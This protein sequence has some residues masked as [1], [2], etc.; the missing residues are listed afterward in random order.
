MRFPKLTELDKDQNEIYNGAPPEGTVL[1]IGPPGTGKTVIAF[2]R[3]QM[4]SRLKRNPRVIMYNKV[5][6]Q[7]TSSRGSVAPDVEVQTLHKWAYDW[8]KRSIRGYGDPPCV[9]GARFDH[10]WTAIQNAAIKKSND[11]AGAKLVNWGHLIIDEGQD[12]PPSLYACLTNV[13]TVANAKGSSPKLAVTVLAD[14]NQRL[15]P[16]RNSN[17]E[18][19]RQ[20]LLLGPENFFHLKKNYRSTKQIAEFASCFYVGL[21]SGKP[22][23]PSSIGELPVVSWIERDT[24]G[25]FLDA[26]ATKIARYA[27][28]RR[29][30]E[31]GVL[32]VRDKVRSSIFNRLNAKLDEKKIKV[33]S[34]SSKDEELK[35]TNLEFDLP[36]SVTVINSASAKGLEF[37]TVFLIDPGALVSTGSG[38]LEAK[39]AMYVLCSR[40]RRFLN[41]MLVEDANSKKLMKDVSK[42]IYEEENL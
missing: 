3:A 27:D 33:Q 26:C 29:T 38:D 37:D 34:Y 22:I 35:A 21:R 12:F 19:I 23:A 41:V 39:M 1:I 16:G 13:M 7:Y 4:L 9:D 40:P 36:G 25:K 14:E 42:A 28:I 31:I 24:E 10:D 18:E 6:S 17:I 8:W 20:N 5:L 11:S 30:E 32:T 2:H 15:R